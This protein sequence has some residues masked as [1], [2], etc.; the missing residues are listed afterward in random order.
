[1]QVDDASILVMGGCG[2]IES[3]PNGLLLRRNQPGNVFIL[4][5]PAS[6]DIRDEK[7]ALEAGASK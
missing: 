7:P 6:C 1:M 3:T 4:N 5:N 2:R